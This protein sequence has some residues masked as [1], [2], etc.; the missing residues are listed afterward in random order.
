MLR[1]FYRLLQFSTL[2]MG[3]VMVRT[4][5]AAPHMAAVVVAG[6]LILEWATFGRATLQWTKPRK[7]FEAVL[8]KVR[9]VEPAPEDK[10]G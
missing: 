10:L 9:D 5:G 7:K 1:A 4:E 8:A 2:C 6:L 3:F